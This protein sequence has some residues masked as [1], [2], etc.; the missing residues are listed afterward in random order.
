MDESGRNIDK[1]TYDVFKDA[2]SS[3]SQNK[4]LPHAELFNQLNKKLKNKFSCN[5]S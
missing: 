1:K 4:E 2:I 5:I 3:R